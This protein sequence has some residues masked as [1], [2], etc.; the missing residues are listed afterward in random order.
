[1]YA[2]FSFVS[3]S[4]A[5][6]LLETAWKFVNDAY[7]TD[8]VLLYPPHVVAL[9]A[10]YSGAFMHNKDVSSWF[11]DLNVNINDIGQAVTE[12]MRVYEVWNSPSFE[13]DTRA[14]LER[15][16]RAN[17]TA[18]TIVKKAAK[19]WKSKVCPKVSLECA[20]DDKWW[21]AEKARREEWEMKRILRDEENK[22]LLNDTKH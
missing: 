22:D 1:M 5:P 9:A 12:I 13:R 8:V 2:L 15:V 20:W 6:E 17:S 11:G 21:K 14:I 7:F 16:P 3:D 10:V 19:K 18:S 4:G